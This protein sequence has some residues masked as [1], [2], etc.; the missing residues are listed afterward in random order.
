MIGERVIVTNSESECFNQEFVVTGEHP[1]S[2]GDVWELADENDTI[3]IHEDSFELVKD[4][5]W[6]LIDNKMT[7]IT[8]AE[9][10]YIDGLTKR[11]TTTQRGIPLWTNLNDV[12]KPLNWEI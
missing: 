6:R 9:D 2:W 7:L 4:M 8:K 10:S 11:N 12:H 5:V 1:M 3:Y